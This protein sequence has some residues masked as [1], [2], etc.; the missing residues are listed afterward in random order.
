MIVVCAGALVSNLLTA[1]LSML[2]RHIVDTLTATADSVLPWVAA[3]LTLGIVRFAAGYGRRVGA[4]RLSLDVQHDLRRDLFAAL[5][6][7]D[8]RQRAGLYT[9]QVVSRTITDVTLIQM[10]LQL[11][12]LVAGSVVLLVASLALIPDGLWMPVPRQGFST[13]RA[14]TTPVGCCRRCRDRRWRRRIWSAL[15]ESGFTAPID[16]DITCA[17]RLR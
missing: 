10:F 11:L 13:S 15:S 8:G 12:P 2:V 3:L 5:L 1:A 14:T 4:S 6:R 9:G 16:E 7:L 17:S